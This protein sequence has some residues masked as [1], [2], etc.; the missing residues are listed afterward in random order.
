MNGRTE[1]TQHYLTRLTELTASIR[2]ATAA[3]EAAR[4]HQADAQSLGD[5]DPNV[6]AAEKSYQ[7]AA[8]AELRALGELAA[9][10]AERKRIFDS[11][12]ALTFEQLRLGASRALGRNDPLR[13]IA[14][15]G[16][17]FQEVVLRLVKKFNSDQLL[18]FPNPAAFYSFVTLEFSREVGNLC[19]HRDRQPQPVGD[20]VKPIPGPDD[21]AS[22]IE[23][24]EIID[25]LDPE[26]AVIFRLKYMH[27]YS[28]AEIAAALGLGERTTARRVEK[29][30]E[31]MA[32]YLRRVTE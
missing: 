28:I 31:I 6:R 23:I 3:A 19:R 13:A 30:K 12:L 14:D 26:L 20:A 25:K 10:Q 11:F 27:N 7:T 21:G 1:M 17:I 18:S 8:E 4:A 32:G 9:A 24:N 16:D 2:A 15:S 29:A 22:W 5:A